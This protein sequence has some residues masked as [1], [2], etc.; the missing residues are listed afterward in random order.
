[1]YSHI[2]CGYNIKQ[3]NVLFH[4]FQ[5][6]SEMITTYALCGFSNVVALG[7]MIGAL[8]AVMPSRKQDIVNVAFRALISGCMACFLT[9]CVAG[10]YIVYAS[11]QSQAQI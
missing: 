11:N 10:L 7:I 1:M 9:A 8:T 4:F 6:H 2:I 5:P 3:Y